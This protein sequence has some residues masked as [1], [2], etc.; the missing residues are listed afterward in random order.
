MSVP[1]MG[2]R[3]PGIPLVS[4]SVPFLNRALRDERHSVR[5]LRSSLPN[6]V[7]MDRHSL[8]FHPVFH[9]DDDFIPFADLY[10]R[11]GDHTI[12][13]QDPPFD[14]VGQNALAI[15]PYRISSVRCANLTRTK[16]KK[17]SH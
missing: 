11:P 12:S 4:K 6:S 10:A 1:E 5:V 17:K 16:K 13:G 9:V 7:P 14:T 8:T 3:I 2:S 15:A